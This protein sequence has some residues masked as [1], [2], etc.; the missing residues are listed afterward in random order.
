MKRK[1]DVF[2]DDDG[3]ADMVPLQRSPARSKNGRQ[4]RGEELVTESVILCCCFASCF[5]NQA[6]SCR[7]LHMQGQAFWL[8]RLGSNC[9]A[10]R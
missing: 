2:T 4:L 1:H 6:R 9:K 10:A 3:A 5:Y 8:E 7:P